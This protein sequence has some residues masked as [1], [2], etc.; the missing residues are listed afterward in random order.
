MA[1]VFGSWLSDAIVVRLS[2]GFGK[3]C[4]MCCWYGVALVGVRGMVVMTLVALKFRPLHSLD[5]DWFVVQVVVAVGMG[6]VGFSFV[7]AFSPCFSRV[8]YL[9]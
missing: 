3:L 1:I 7:A 9:G 4:W 6:W 8:D 5:R 2:C